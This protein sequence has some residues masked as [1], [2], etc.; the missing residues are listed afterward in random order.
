M[1][2]IPEPGT[3]RERGSPTRLLLER[4]AEVA[5]LSALVEAARSG[6]GR[7]V[8]IEGAA[9]I[10]KT[11]LVAEARA[12]ATEFEVLSAR[13]GELESDFAFGVVR[14]LFEGAL[15]A[16]AAD[17][18]AE[19]LS[20]AAALASPLFEA[21]PADG[22]PGGSETSFAI[23]HGL[24]W[25][26]ANFALHRPTLLIVD[27][28]HWADEPSLRW[29]SYLARR[30]EGLPLVLLVATRPPQQSEHPALV[31]EL[32]MDPAAVVIRPATLSDEAVKILARDCSRPS[33]TLEFCE[34]CR[35]TTGGNPLFLRALLTTLAD[36]GVPPVGQ[37]AARVRDVGPQPVARAVSLRLS[38]LS[39]EAEAL[40]RAIAV[41]GQ[42][43]E[44]GHAAALAQIERPVAFEAAAALARAELIRGD[45]VLEFAHPVVRAAIYET[46]EGV[47]R[48]AAHHRAAAVL[49]DAGVEPEQSASHL[50]LVPPAG[51]QFVTAVL[52]D[53][54][55]RAVR[56]GSAA[57]AVTYMRRALAESPASEERGEM[58]WELGRAERGVDLPASLEHLGEAVE[59]I[60]DPVRHAELA[61]DYG[62]AEMYANLDR[63]KTI[64]TFREAIRRLGADHPKV[65]ELL[66]AELLNGAL[67]G[68]PE[69]Y[70]TVT[71]LV[72]AVDDHS[73]SGGFGADLLLAGLA[74]YETRRGLDRA[75]TVDLAERA[76]ASGLVERT[77]GH[78]LYYP[79]HALGAAGNMSAATAYYDRAI[80]H[81]RR[82]GDL[83]SLAG[84]L[85]FRGSLAT[86]RGELL[87]AEQDLREGLEL[88]KQAG[89]AG[90]VMYS[91]AWLTDFLLE[92]GA[93]EEAEATH[94]RGRPARAGPDEPTFHLL[95]RSTRETALGATRPCESARR[96]SSDRSDRRLGRDL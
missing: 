22:E 88:S 75:R 27:D 62:R 56:R 45:A 61:L 72:S 90:N 35:A 77:A 2:V 52:G 60:D 48:V 6:D 86:D 34:A 12:L 79:P 3:R 84:L 47:E 1:T 8:V 93:L 73:L 80:D 69:L 68:G 39:P 30:L 4:E 13:A 64:E 44:L 5:A 49:A 26:A 89:V 7:L 25:L 16:A 51:D 10:G 36:D 85:G 63:P 9:G 42:S 20:G 18:R 58:L 67:G 96:L 50:L 95:P 78:A 57:T 71:E 91:A 37:S 40:A 38:R 17:T 76:V 54:G 28:L 53:A 94:R 83:L 29:L 11:R 14:Q 82:G 24:Y 59:L 46:I 66:E 70:P 41:L 15:S 74:H 43:A 81:A 23:L 92:R 55:R 32:L 65:R 21:V 31:T 19:L 87:S 33:R